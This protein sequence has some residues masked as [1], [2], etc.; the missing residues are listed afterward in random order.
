MLPSKYLSPALL[1]EQ[2]RYY[3][4]FGLR[5]IDLPQLLTV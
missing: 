5:V 4:R 1:A 3:A 2:A